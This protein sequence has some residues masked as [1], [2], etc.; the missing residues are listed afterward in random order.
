MAALDP[1]FLGN[2]RHRD[3]HAEDV[4]AVAFEMRTRAF[5]RSSEKHLQH[6][7]GNVHL[8]GVDEL[9]ARRV[10]E[11]EP[12]DRHCAEP[13]PAVGRSLAR[14]SSYVFAAGASVSAARSAGRASWWRASR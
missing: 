10:D 14:H 4:L 8:E 12:A 11:V 6:F 1:V 13:R 3:E 7:G 5:D 9:L 2:R